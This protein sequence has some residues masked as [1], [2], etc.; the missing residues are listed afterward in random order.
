MSTCRPS[1]R[2]RVLVRLDALLARER[3]LWAKGLERVVG[4]DEAG[5]GPLAG[6]VVAAAVVFAPGTGIPGVDDSK[7]L[8]PARRELLAAEIRRFALAHAVAAAE[9]EEIDRINIYQATLLAMRRAVE[10]LPVRP[11]RV[12]VDARR[13]PGIDVPQE[14]IIRGDASCHVIAAAS[15]LAKVA[16]DA[17]M[18]D[19]DAAY[20]GYGF[21]LHKGYPTEA[22][23]SAIRRLGPCPIHR[24]S[25][26]LLPQRGLWE[27]TGES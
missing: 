17:I 21:A 24:R 16:R 1:W 12:L 7:R 9:P 2:E 13:I 18:A 23:R 3:D 5:V 11:D 27:G 22:H 14:A 15:I 10:A 20:P 6:P 19:H 26:T 25:F 8:T 4:V